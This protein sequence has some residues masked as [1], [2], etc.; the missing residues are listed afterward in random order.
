MTRLPAGCIALLAVLAAC[1]SDS[2]GP[3]P[4]PNLNCGTLQ[5]ATLAP[6]QYVIIDPINQSPCA[7]VPAS[8]GGSAE[9][10]YVAASTAGTETQSGISGAYSITGAGGT[11][12]SASVAALPEPLLKAFRPP[13]GAAQFHHMLRLREQAEAASG[14]VRFSAAIGA[15]PNFAVAPT[16]GSQKTFNVCATTDCTSFVQVSATAKNVGGKVAIYQED[17]LP[18]GV[19]FTQTEIDNVAQLFDGYLY[20]IDTTNFG[21]ESDIDANGVVEVLLSGKINAL[22]KSICS[23]GSVILGYFLSTDLNPSQAGSNKGEVFYSI[24]PDTASTLTPGCTPISR[25]FASSNLAP[26]FIHEFQHMISYAQHVLVA[27]GSSSEET[28]LNEGLSH[29]AEELGGRLIPNAANPTLPSGS[30]TYGQF[31]LSNFQNAYGYLEQPEGTF[32]IEP[33]SSS[34]ELEE[35]GANW[36]FVRWAADQFGTS[37]PNPDPPNFVVR[38]TNFTRSLVQTAQVGAVN[39]ANRTGRSFSDLVT[40]WQMANYLDNLPGFSPADSLIQY[41]NLDLRNIYS[42]L[43]ASSP[44]FFPK[45]YPLVPDVTTGTYTKS[46]TLRQGSA[47]HVRIQQAAG[48][49]A[50]ALKLTASSNTPISGTLVPRIGLVRIK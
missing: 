18:A 33:I 32:L 47:H 43:N 10:L 35:R 20:P 22:S 13:T 39:V 45:P 23:Q 19:G 26:T 28:W 12:A 5:P 34:G 21:R 37:T 8:G 2:T 31:S 44:S 17:G 16:V 4:G 7:A 3:N 36:L 24:V 29:Y 6:G 38:A 15:G 14:A 40:L 30:N 25:R 1:S 50:V 42:Q 46:G 11:A 9:Y 49:A 41:R 48:A 27:N